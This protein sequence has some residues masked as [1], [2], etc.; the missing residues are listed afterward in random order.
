MAGAKSFGLPRISY[1][2][3]T[4]SI[5][6]AAS[7]RLLGRYSAGAGPGEEIS[8]GIFSIAGG[9]L[10][11]PATAQYDLVGRATA[12]AGDMEITNRPALNIAGLEIANLFTTG[13]TIRVTAG[14]TF[15]TT[16]DGVAGV[17][18]V[19]RY[20][21]SANGPNT[22][23][24]KARGTQAAPAISLTNDESALLVFRAYGDTGFV[25]NGSITCVVIEPVPSNAAMG[26][27][28]RLNP[29]PLGAAGTAEMARFD[30]PSGFQMFGAN[31]VVDANR[32]IRRRVFTFAT[33][34]AAAGIAG[35]MAQISDGAAAP[36]W[37][38][39]AAG[40]GAV[41]TPVFST[42]AAWN[43]G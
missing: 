2:I 20:Q 21:N 6:F 42:G 30:H 36:A 17:V 16:G 12:G 5:S 14:S 29:T 22:S 10:A 4:G 24:Q 18:N 43:N 31:I 1:P 11:L 37:N 40:G 26:G 34:P 33:L 9:T 39:A 13:Q 27:S 15:T 8:L 7:P 23:F 25:T 32:V 38:A 35:A 41:S 19:Q 28:I 3:T